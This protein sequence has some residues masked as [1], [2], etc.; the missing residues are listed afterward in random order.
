MCLRSDWLTSYATESTPASSR[1]T[2]AL[3]RLQDRAE[4]LPLDVVR[5]VAEEELGTRLSAAFTTVNTDPL[6]KR[7]RWPRCT[8]Q[9]CATAAPS[10]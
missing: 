7:P 6:G 10:P 1:P 5:Q 8:G 4:P 3:R 2:E 9:S